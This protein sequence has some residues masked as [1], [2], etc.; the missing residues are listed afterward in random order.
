MAA[1]R[2]DVPVPSSPKLLERVRDALR[3]R[4]YSRRTE[5]AYATWIRRFIVFHGKRHPQEMAEPEVTR[6]LS[7]LAVSGGVS[8]STQ[9]QAASALLFLYSQVLRQQIDWSDQVIRARRPTRLPVVLT[10]E[11]VTQILQQLHGTSSLMAS[12]LYGS[13][14]RVIECVQLRVK[15]VDIARREIVIRDGKGQKDRRTMLPMRLIA[16]LTAHLAARKALHDRDLRAQCGS[17]E[18]PGALRLK[19]SKAPWAWPWQW[20]FPAT[21]FYRDTVSGER[22]RHHLHESVLQ[23]A[24][25]DATGRTGITKPAT[26]HTLRHSFATHLLESGSDI[27]TIQELLGHRDVRTTMI[28]T[29]V[30]NRG[31]PGVVSPLDQG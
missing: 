5:E 23:R 26:C 10:R 12:L 30:L 6:F 22:R 15:D 7:S 25:K 29:H 16:P 13:G 1:E 27:R 31:G 19:Y 28:Y 2:E 4:H 21:R 14:L 17:V 24:V 8:A 3:T 18:L 9:N 20:V 11:E